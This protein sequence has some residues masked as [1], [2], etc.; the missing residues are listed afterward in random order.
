MKK[1]LITI[2]FFI[3]FLGLCFTNQVF[4][5]DA[6]TE[7][8]NDGLVNITKK[9][10]DAESAITG[11]IGAYNGYYVAIFQGE[12]KEPIIRYDGSNKNESGNIGMGCLGNLKTNED[13]YV[14]IWTAES[15]YGS[16]NLKDLRAKA[17]HIESYAPNRS[18]ICDR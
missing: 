2:I 15:G 13:F 14:F 8:A 3:I 1:I 7:Q 12:K 10:A 5:V 17:L 18:C 4:A 16:D 6:T 11:W 9:S